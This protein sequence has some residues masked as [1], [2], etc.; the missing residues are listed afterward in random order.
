MDTAVTIQ[1]L[2]IRLAKASG[3]LALSV[4]FGVAGMVATGS[5]ADSLGWCC[6]HSWA[7]LHGSGIAVL[8][9]WALVGFHLVTMTG[10]RLN[11]LP[12]THRFAALPHVAYVCTALGTVI[13]TDSLMWP[14]MA[15]SAIATYFGLKGAAWSYPVG[16]SLAALIVSLGSLA[17]WLYLQWVFSQ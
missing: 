9:A 17:Y 7:L 15:L 4:A 13:F 6:V 11:W 1:P 10:S 16:L 12:K 14:G 2:G 5:V 8:M 3:V